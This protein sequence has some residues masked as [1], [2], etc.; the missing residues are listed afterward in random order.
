MACRTLADGLPL[1]SLICVNEL[2]GYLVLECM[3]LHLYICTG[4]PIVLRVS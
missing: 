3:L 4:V 1:N 2:P